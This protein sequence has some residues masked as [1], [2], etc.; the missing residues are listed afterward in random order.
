M[1][2]E[3]VACG[4]KCRRERNTLE[5]RQRRGTPQHLGNCTR[6]RIAEVVAAETARA[7]VELGKNREQVKNFRIRNQ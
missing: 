3:H 2:G 6:T 5:F 1:N 4:E 7:F